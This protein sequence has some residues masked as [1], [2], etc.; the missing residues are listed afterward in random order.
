MKNVLEF[1]AKKQVYGSLIII[2]VTCIIYQIIVYIINRITV[3]GKDEL[4]KKKRLTTIELFKNISRYL[5]IIFMIWP[6]K[7]DFVSSLRPCIF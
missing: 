3:H 7:V 2:L 5:L 1:L 6:P 4:E